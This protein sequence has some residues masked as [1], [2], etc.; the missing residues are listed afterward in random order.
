MKKM[1]AALAI[2]ALAVGN[3]SACKFTWYHYGDESTKMLIGQDIGSHVTDEY[4]AKFN[5]K[6]ELFVQSTA[7]TLSNMT[8]G[9]SIVG[10]RPRGSK[11]H[12]GDTYTMLS[13]DTNGR[14]SGEAQ[15]LAVKAT[16]KAIDNLMSELATYNAQ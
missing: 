2:S 1:I 14:T 8:A 9:H 10:I 5:A 4:C 13:T 7:Y 16:L 15:R 12:P 3:A 6:N 11:T